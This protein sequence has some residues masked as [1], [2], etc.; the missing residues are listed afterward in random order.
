MAALWLNS[1]PVITCNH[2]FIHYLQTFC[3]FLD[4]I[5]K[6]NI[7]FVIIIECAGHTGYHRGLQSISEH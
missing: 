2:P 7:I 3:G 5:L 4:C 1:I 6:R